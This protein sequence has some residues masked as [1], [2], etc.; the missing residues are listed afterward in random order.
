MESCIKVVGKDES[1]EPTVTPVAAN[2]FLR[3]MTL[4]SD[5]VHNNNGLPEFKPIN[6]CFDHFEEISMVELRLLIL[7]SPTKLCGL[8]PVSTFIVKEH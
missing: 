1:V 2:D 5:L 4:K 8:D 7:S 6:S 3:L